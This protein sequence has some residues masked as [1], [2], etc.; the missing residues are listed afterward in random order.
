[1]K[2]LLC[3]IAGETLLIAAMSF[4]FW[5]ITK[6]L[7]RTK[8]KLKVAHLQIAAL[9]ALYSQLQDIRIKTDENIEKLSSV[10]AAIEYLA[11]GDE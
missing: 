11:G 7:E 5:V 6:I 8:E 3:I 10:D 4:A 2:I 9:E 1:M